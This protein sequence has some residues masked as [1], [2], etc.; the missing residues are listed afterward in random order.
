MLQ[1]TINVSCNT[2]FWNKEIVQFKTSNYNKIRFNTHQ[3]FD[4]QLL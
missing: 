3:N 2:K 1:L 4:L